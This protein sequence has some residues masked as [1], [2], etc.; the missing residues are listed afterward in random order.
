VILKDGTQIRG[1]N[2]AAT[3]WCSAAVGAFAGAGLPLDATLLSVFILAGNT[4]LRPL[5]NYVNRCPMLV[6]QTEAKY[7]VHATCGQSDVNDVRDV[8]SDALEATRYPVREF[9]IVA[10]RDGR[11]EVT[12]VLVPTEANPRELDAVVDAVERSPKVVSATWTVETA[13]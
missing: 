6:S 8:L 1:L 7:Q 9:R 12:A 4:L 2:T 11:T 5:V 3:L 10:E 13:G